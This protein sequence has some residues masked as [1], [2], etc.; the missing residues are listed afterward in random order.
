MFSPNPSDLEV[1]TESLTFASAHSSTY[2]LTIILQASSI[3]IDGNLSGH[4]KASVRML[5]AANVLQVENVECHVGYVVELI[6]VL[7]IVIVRCPYYLVTRIHAMRFPSTV[8]MEDGLLQG[9]VRLVRVQHVARS[10]GD[11]RLRLLHKLALTL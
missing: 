4:D 9:I 8:R 5:V 6:I 3:S 10:L 2:F 7:L 11:F 1:P